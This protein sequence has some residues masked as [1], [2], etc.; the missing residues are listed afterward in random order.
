MSESDPFSPDGPAL[1]VDGNVVNRPARAEPMLSEV[2]EPPLELPDAP[3]RV[4]EPAPTSYREGAPVTRRSV[5]PRLVALLV[6]LM[7]LAGGVA[8]AVMLVPYS[9]WPPLLRD[10]VQQSLALRSRATVVVTSEPT[11]AV[12]RIAGQVVGTTPWAGDNVWPETTLTVEMPGYEPFTRPL[13][14]Q[15]DAVVRAELRRK[16]RPRP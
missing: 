9:A 4:H 13:A 11:G 14:G 2:P 15:R 3:R 5:W 16:G 8:A 10:L 6:L 7:L 12:V 1:D